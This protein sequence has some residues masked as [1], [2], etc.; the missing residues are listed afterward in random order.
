VN[1]TRAFGER[2]RRHRERSGITVQAVAEATK[3]ASSM[4]VALERGDCDRWPGGIY[5]RSWIR[6]YARAIGL[7]ADETGAEFNRLFARNAFLEGESA[8]MTAATAADMPP[9]TPLR[10]TFDRDPA[11]HIHRAVRRTLLFVADLALSAAAAAAL[12]FLTALTFWT[13]FAGAAV[14]CHAL[15]LFGGGGSAAGWI[16]RTIRRHSRPHEEAA[17]SAVAEA[18]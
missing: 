14:I 13:S 12:A 8:A 17:D 7:D 5:S 15:G 3:I 16:E 2:L 1:S 6:A 9:I 11:E 18:V 4:L 10:M